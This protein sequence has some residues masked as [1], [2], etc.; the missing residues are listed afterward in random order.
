MFLRHLILNFV[1]ISTSF[2][3]SF[4]WIA[5]PNVFKGGIAK[6]H[7]FQKTFT[8]LT[9]ITESPLKV[10]QIVQLDNSYEKESEVK[11]P[12][13]S[14]PCIVL[15]AGFEEFNIALY[16]EAAREA[17]KLVPSVSIYVFTDVDI[18]ETPS[19]VEDALSK[20][21][22]FFGS[23][24]FDFEKVSWIKKRITG[25]KTRFCFESALELMSDTKVGNFQMVGGKG[26]GPPA[27]VKAILKQFGSGKEEDRLAGYL[28]LLKFGSSL[29]KWVPGDGAKDLRLWLST[30]S[31]WNQGA[32][33]NIIAMFLLLIKELQL[34]PPN[35]IP[36]PSPLKETP[37]NGFIHP[38]LPSYLSSPSQY[39][40]WFLQ[41]RPWVTESTPRVAVLL[42]RKHV[43][44]ELSYIPELI[45]QLEAEGLFPIP[46]FINGVEA[47]TIVRDS[48]TTAFEQVS[49]TTCQ[50][51]KA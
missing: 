18:Q 12:G 38:D 16:R 10:N 39:E 37:A 15:I 32:K 24:L 41:T 26:A 22:V 49:I 36:S 29:L 42:Y 14:A 44:S 2:D 3:L 6:Q 34:A 47:H 19:S 25:I 23:L 30:Y 9:A 35:S 20:A 31:Y 45:R 40:K 1:L 8:K 5:L 13:T 43:I 33:D 50:F 28:N 7:Y 46:I 21:D 51:V 17:M 48:L 11:L 4:G 27:P